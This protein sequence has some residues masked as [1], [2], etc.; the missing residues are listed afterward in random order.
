MATVNPAMMPP[1]GPAPMQAILPI[2]VTK[3][4][5]ILAKVWG[6]MSL[7]GVLMVIIGVCIVGFTLYGTRRTTA[8]I[9]LNQPAAVKNPKTGLKYGSMLAGLGGSI[10]AVHMAGMFIGHKL[11]R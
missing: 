2:A 1:V 4:Q 5:G 3:K 10:V 9:L 8:Q 11:H 6:M 7:M